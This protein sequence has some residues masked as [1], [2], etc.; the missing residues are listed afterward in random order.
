MRRI[1]HEDR[2][3][4]CLQ[5]VIETLLMREGVRF[6][7]AGRIDLKKFGWKAL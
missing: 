3:P 2:H 4:R 6:S 1:H 7:R 5:Q